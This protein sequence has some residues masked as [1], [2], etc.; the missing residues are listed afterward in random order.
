M[1]ALLAK[2][3]GARSCWAGVAGLAG[4]VLVAAALGLAPARAAA[5]V[6]PKQALVV[7]N[8][9]YPDHPLANPENDAAD[10][11]TKLSGIGFAVTTVRNG[12]RAAMLQAV[13]QHAARLTRESLSVFYFAGHG[14]QIAGR[15]F[16]VPV[17]AR[18]E[19]A[20]DML[21]QGVSIDEVI[22]T[23]AQAR[24]RF[25][26]LILDAC[27]DNPFGDGKIAGL[28]P[29][30]APA[31]TLIAFATAPGKVAS[32][33]RG[34]NGLYT[35]HLLRHV[36]SAERRVEE[37]FKLVRVGVLE[38][39]SG[40]Q[41]P[42][43][44]TALTADL[45]LARFPAAAAP[46]A[47]PAP[48]SATAWIANAGE[49]ELR[50]YLAQ[51]R[52][53]T[54][55]EPV[56]ARLV[57]LR[58][59]APVRR[60]ALKLADAPC[61]GCPRLTPVDPPGPAALWVGT[62]LVTVAEWGRC[63]AA[64]ACPAL[65]DAP[66]GEAAAWTPAAGV[67]AQAAARY[68]AWL[69]AQGTGAGWRFRL[70]THEEWQRVYRA[71]FFDERGRALFGAESACRYANLYDQN[72]AQAQRF[73]WPSLPCSDGFAEASPVGLFLPSALGLFDVI[74]NLWQWTA[75]CAEPAPDGACR[76]QRLAGGSWATGKN[77]SWERPPTLAAEPDLA[78]PIFG[79]RVVAT[80]TAR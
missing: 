41:L 12:G 53:P 23:I 50:Q 51:N 42:W 15:N 56:T 21:T 5:Q 22:A 27:R 25:N 73:D 2:A 44:N 7:G 28:A 69:D 65:P 75:S 40:Q 58:A 3:A 10:L 46:L 13:R 63:V 74:G 68:L 45:A 32:D 29:L 59:E 4:L 55:R 35:S 70:P 8:A 62:D 17:D 57:A 30:D 26:V 64:R 38:D 80:R 71:G 72:G 60:E 52:D 43:E 54:L 61:P 39:S 37:V 77:W 48:P 67:S 33:G 9:Q 66:R 6:G 19:R 79:L 34:R 11:T 36:A 18:L 76:R 31:D 78:A 20:E 1:V 16:L 49:R 47:P 14:V 24:P